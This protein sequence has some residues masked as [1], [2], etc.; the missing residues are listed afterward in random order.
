MAVSP[1]S[2]TNPDGRSGTKPRWMPAA[3]ILA[4]IAA[5]ALFCLPITERPASA[6]SAAGADVVVESRQLDI[7]GA[8]ITVNLM[9]GHLDLP[10]ARVFA[11]VTRAARAVSMY[12]GG[13]PVTRAEVDVRPG[14]GRDGVFH[15]F[16]FLPDS[17]VLTTRIGVG[18]H[19]TEADL[20]NDWM[21]THELVHMTF[22]GMAREH[23]WIE[24]GIATYV[25]PIARVQDGQ[26]PMN[27]VWQQLVDGL[28]KGEPQAGDEGLD[29]T[30]TWGRTYWGGALFC[31]MADIGIRRATKNQLGLQDALRG[32][33][34]ARGSMEKDWTIEHALEIGDKATGTDVLMKLYEK[35]KAAPAPVD[36]A[37]MWKELGVVPDNGT[38]TFRD[39]A[40]LA[41]IRKAITE[42]PRAKLAPVKP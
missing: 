21:M 2:K 17:G 10:P 16:T 15:G 39:D 25:E 7:G 26:L 27:S 3:G 14:E 13:F 6:S 12:Y 24:E 4:A 29:H 11:W 23:H 1:H 22:P 41:A 5:G 38:V 19:T 34:A 36:L 30:H 20:E 8:A 40:P 37:Q 31:L 18:E 32:I 9:A 42:P 33:V 35:M 28:P